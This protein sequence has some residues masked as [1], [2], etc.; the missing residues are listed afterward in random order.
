MSY[1]LE[2][3]RKSEKARR[4]ERASTLGKITAPRRATRP[5]RHALPSRRPLQL[6]ILALV[7]AALVAILV[8]RGKVLPDWIALALWPTSAPTLSSGPQANTERATPAPA[9][10]EAA[11]QK[12]P[13]LQSVSRRA[14]E[15]DGA[16][17]GAKA[18]PPAEETAANDGRDLPV[19]AMA[20]LPPAI[21]ENIG[22]M[23]FAGHAYS[24]DRSLRLI[25]INNRILHEGDPVDA[26]LRLAEITTSGVVLLYGNR[27][28][29]VDLF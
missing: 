3:L 10:P 2:A 23:R 29:R 9:L 7:M 27:Q 20:E 26:H 21:Q 25:M 17:R 6:L 24:R 14:A 11:V 16:G 22:H 4:Q 5:Q 28:V 15:A 8:G 13:E 18:P 1:I 12:G 19:V